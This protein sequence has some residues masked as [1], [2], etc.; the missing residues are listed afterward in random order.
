MEYGTEALPLIDVGVGNFATRNARY[1]AAVCQHFNLQWVSVG[2]TGN[3]FFEAVSTCFAH[4][5]DPLTIS[6]T[7]LRAE[8]VAWLVECE[9]GVPP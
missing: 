2:G 7:D 1:R 9:V 6:A 4:L 3:C 8:V 5:N